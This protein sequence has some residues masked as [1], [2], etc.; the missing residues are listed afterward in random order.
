MA[1]F[2]G[3][4]TRC[5]CALPTPAGLVYVSGSEGGQAASAHKS[6]VSQAMSGLGPCG[7]KLAFHFHTEFIIKMLKD[8]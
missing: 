1:G 5:I 7:V 8:K 2:T 4:A 3:I 6:L